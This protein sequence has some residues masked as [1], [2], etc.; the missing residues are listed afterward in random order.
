M[1]A[2]CSQLY[3]VFVAALAMYVDVEDDDDDDDDQSCASCCCLYFVCFVH[4][5]RRLVDET[6]KMVLQRY[7]FTRTHTRTL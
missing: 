3:K 7:T 5:L 4:M 1:C 2:Y 6:Y